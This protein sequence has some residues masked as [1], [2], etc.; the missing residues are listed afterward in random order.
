MRICFLPPKMRNDKRNSQVR[1]DE[2]N[3]NV[4]VKQNSQ[5]SRNVFKATNKTSPFKTSAFQNNRKRNTKG[6][7]ETLSAKPC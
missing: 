5:G 3:A 7:S 1:A 4:L 6:K 2:S